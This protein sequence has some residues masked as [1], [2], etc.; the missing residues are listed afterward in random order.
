MGLQPKLFVDLDLEETC[1]TKATIIRHK[2][3]LSEVVYGNTPFDVHDG[4]SASFH[5]RRVSLHCNGSLH[6]TSRGSHRYQV[7]AII[8]FSVHYKQR[9]STMNSWSSSVSPHWFLPNAYWST[10][11][12]I[13]STPPSS[14]CRAY[15]PTAEFWCTSRFVP[16]TPS[17]RWWWR[18]ST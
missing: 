4:S 15:S 3:E 11:I 17:G 5:F 13:P 1:I 10:S 9:V 2:S 16:M 14:T 6:L 18:I 7:D 8:H 12:P